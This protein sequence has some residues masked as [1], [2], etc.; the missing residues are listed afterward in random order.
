MTIRKIPTPIGAYKCQCCRR[1]RQ[2]VRIRGGDSFPYE[3][4]HYCIER[5]CQQLATA[6]GPGE[7]ADHVGQVRRD[8]L[9]ITE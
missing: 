4:C 6:M 1:K 3:L 7:L 8:A 5:L 2:L 9:G